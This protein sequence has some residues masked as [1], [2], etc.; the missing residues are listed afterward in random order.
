MAKALAFRRDT[1]KVVTVDTIN[2][3]VTDVGA[4]IS[5]AVTS[6]A[7]PNRTRNN[8]AVYQGDPY[9]LYIHTSGEARVAVYQSGTWSDIPSAALP[10]VSGT[11]V[12]ISLEVVQDYLVMSVWR[13]N[14]ASVDGLLVKRTVDGATWNAPVPIGAPVQPTV[15]EGC[16]SIAWRQVIWYATASGVIYYNPI[17]NT[18]G[19]AFDDG[20]DGNLDGQ[21]ATVGSFAFWNNGLYFLKPGSALS[22]YQLDAAWQPTAPVTPPAWNK[23]PAT[24]IPS[25]GP[26]TIVPDAPPALLFVNK[27]DELCILY[28]AALGSKLVKTNSAAFPVFT[29]T[30]VTTGLL[31]SAIQSISDGGFTL[32]QDDRRRVNEVQNILVH[33]SSSTQLATWD[34]VSEIDVRATFAHRVMPPDERFGALRTFTNLQPTTSITGVAQPWDGR[35]EIDYDVR[36]AS[37]RPVDIFGE[38]SV[39]GDE[40]LPMT[41]GDGD[42]GNEQLATTPAGNSY[43]FFWDAWAD[44]TGTYPNMNMRIVSRISGV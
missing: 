37:S 14:S 38:Y 8:I 20:D 9:L 11:V 7:Y 40:W 3:V 21:D 10:P 23:L 1:G 18:M 15:S 24:G 13:Q 35:V 12:P 4:A 31:P 33:S 36:D 41:Q 17:T 27:I 25:L 43:Q 26:L 32:F 22:L 44:L 39:D 16:T 30:D 29:F 6:T 28:S 19:G 5:G 42:D 2:N 34:G